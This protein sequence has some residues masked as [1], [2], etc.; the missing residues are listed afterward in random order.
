MR[1]VVLQGKP[2][3]SVEDILND[4]YTMEDLKEILKDR[5]KD[6]GRLRSINVCSKADKISL[7]EK[8][9]ELITFW[10]KHEVVE[11]LA[12]QYRVKKSIIRQ[13]VR[14]VEPAD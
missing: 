8:Y 9:R 5:Y 1:A 2:Y 14:G 13:W 12:I 3:V 4:Q 6:H 10:E 7:I 11:R